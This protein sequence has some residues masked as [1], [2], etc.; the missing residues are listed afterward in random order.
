VRIG[1]TLFARA[2]VSGLLVFSLAITVGPLAAGSAGASSGPSPASGPAATVS[3]LTGGHGVFIG[4]PF[5]V[6]VKKVGYVEHEFAA[7]GTATSYTPQG[8]LPSDGRFTFVPSG[9]ARYRTRVLVRYPA[10]PSRFSGTVDVEWLN[11]SGGV[12]ADPDWATLHNEITR[13]GDA[14]VGIS[15]QVI[16]VTG[17]A[18]LVTAPGDNGLAGK[19]LVKIDPAR[20][21]SLTL[22]GDGY[23]FDIYTQVAR[24][25]RA[26]HG[27][28]GLRPE[29]MLAVGESQSAI[30][31]VTY[32]D[33]VQPLTHEFDGF[34]VHSRGGP[35]LPL[36][37]PGQSANLAN[38]IGNPPVLF[39][40]DQ[41][42]PVLDIQSEADLT[43]V[44]DSYSANQ[45]DNARL[46]V[47]EVAGT[48]HADRHLLGTHA[49]AIKCGVPINNGTMYLVA[50]A[51][52]HSLTTWVETGRAPVHAPRIDVAPGASPQIVRA[53]DGIARGGIRTPPVTVPVATLSGVPGPSSSVLCLLIGSTTPFSAARLRALYPSKADYLRRYDAAVSATIKAGFVLPQDRSL[54]LSFADPGALPG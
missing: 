31:L 7:S 11:V 1:G 43:G 14:W 44:L 4:E 25:I 37:G 39:R 35:G 41:S 28:G 45:P 3:P 42:T 29:R 36:V 12:D 53:A 15:T 38:S 40:T 33:G 51:A 52:L 8:G 6:N 30:A 32:Y 23:S 46:R 18:V 50:D 20:Y 22:P 5:T 16:G 34:F 2:A 17:G 47:W 48:A 24:A 10:D 19:G 54:L 13:S 27:L 9:T 21:G 26:G 49:K